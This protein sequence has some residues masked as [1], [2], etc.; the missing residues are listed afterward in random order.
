MQKR[1]SFCVLSSFVSSNI[2]YF[3]SAFSS[4]VLLNYLN[5]RMKT[6]LPF[7][8]MLYRYR[9]NM[10]ISINRRFAIE[11]CYNKHCVINNNSHLLINST[12]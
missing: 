2:F 8:K 12:S 11:I 1:D 6:I 9:S 7:Y 4:R 5:K 10:F 3:E